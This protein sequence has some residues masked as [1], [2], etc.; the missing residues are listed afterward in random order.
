[1]LRAHGKDVVWRSPTH[2]H[3]CTILT[4]LCVRSCACVG[5]RCDRGYAVWAGAGQLA[6]IKMQ[7][8]PNE[9]PSYPRT[10]AELRQERKNSESPQCQHERFYF[11]RGGQ[12]KRSVSRRF[13]K[14]FENMKEPAFYF[15]FFSPL[16]IC[17]ARA[18]ASW[19]MKLF[20]IES[21]TVNIW[22]NW[23]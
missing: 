8:R 5:V 10:Q 15:L 20:G 12:A 2:T 17:A 16:F 23:G 6:K 18:E 22:T 7:K 21:S 11:T 3:T 4:R 19:L 13:L 9:Y 1:M 14:Q